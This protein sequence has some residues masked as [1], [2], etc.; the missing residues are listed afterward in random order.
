MF[1]FVEFSL[2]NSSFPPQKA[3]SARLVNNFYEHEYAEITFKDWGVDVSRVKPGTPIEILIDGREFVGYIHDVK[4]NLDAQNNQTKV[5]AIGAS[6]VMRQASQ[7]VYANTTASEVVKE[8][9]RKHGFSYK[10]EP[11]P[12]IYPQISQAGLTDWELLVKLAKQ[13][14]YFLKVEGTTLYFQPLLKEFEDFINEAPMFSKAEAGFKTLDLM[15]SFSP[16]VGETLSYEGADKSAV[17][18]SG[19]N[20]VTGAVFK[21]VKQVRS[22]STRGQYQTEFFDKYATSVVANSD[23]IANLEAIA[24]DENSKFPYR[25]EAEVLGSGDLR[26]GRAVFINNVGP[27]YTGYWTI[28]GIEHEVIERGV[29]MPE[30]ITTLKLGTD[31]LGEINLPNAL[32][33]PTAGNKTIIPGQKQTQQPV[34]NKLKNTSL[35]V[36]QTNDVKLSSSKNRPRPKEKAFDVADTTW[37]S[38]S[39]DLNRVRRET[40]RSPAAIAKVVQHLASL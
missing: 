26:L 23:D 3:Y 6:Y 4:S 21:A 25:A 5:S 16:V 31:S 15:Y 40:Y 1:K 8:I 9:A 12:R 22:A 37:S 30:F 36:K 27:E 18:V 10:V 17:A 35:R 13:C 14:G 32:P 34:Q 11:H 29:A 33:L 7:E 28:L 39:G 38:D 24:A 19:I 2:P 20:P